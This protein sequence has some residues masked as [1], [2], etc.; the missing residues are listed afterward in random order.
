MP[1]SLDLDAPVAKSRAS[2]TFNAN[3][4]FASLSVHEALF[5]CRA[6]ERP[7][8]RQGRRPKG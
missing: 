1:G 8:T 4:T 3:L 2:R 7:G 5:Q 6:R